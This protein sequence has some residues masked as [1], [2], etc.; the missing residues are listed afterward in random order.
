MRTPAPS[1]RGKLRGLRDRMVV[2]TGDYRQSVLLAGV[3]RSGTTWLEQVINHRNDYREMF[4]PFHPEKTPDCAHFKIFQYLRPDCRDPRYLSPATR[5]V[6][7]HIHSPWI[8]RFNHRLL[9][10]RRLIK[11]IRA[12]LLLKWLHARFPGMPLLLML[13]HPCAVA[14]S[15][16]QL[17]WRTRG[18]DSM[19][20]QPELLEDFLAPFAEEIRAAQDP[21]ER[22][23][24]NWCVLNYVPLRQFAAG[25]I[26]LIFFEECCAQPG[27]EAQ[28]LFDFLGRPFDETVCARMGRPS[29]LSRRDSA[30]VKGTDRLNDWRKYISD[31]QIRRAMQILRRFGLDRIY[32]GD[33]R[34]DVQ[35]AH[36]MLAP[37]REQQF[38]FARQILLM[39][40]VSLGQ[41]FS[42]LLW[43]LCGCA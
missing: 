15:W 24:W 10:R 28:R 1:L 38:G 40:L 34:P 26:H 35:A 22:Y 13:R 31:G 19:L 16:L 9:A 21:F 29:P 7:G 39:F 42:S 27:D 11:D 20:E 12:N 23:V 41:E 6:T 8:D 43:D 2:D 32:N 14:S 18:L 25:E 33:S 3:G 36:A 17:K 37:R 5:I 30:V 4:E